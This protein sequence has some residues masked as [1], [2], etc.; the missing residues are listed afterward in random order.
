MSSSPQAHLR[1]RTDAASHRHQHAGRYVSAL[2]P[3]SLHAN[4]ADFNHAIGVFEKSAA[5]QVQDSWI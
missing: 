3:G 5:D 1:E 4:F 2:N